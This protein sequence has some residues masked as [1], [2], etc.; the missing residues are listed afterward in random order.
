MEY[1]NIMNKFVEN[2]VYGIRWWVL[3][4]DDNDGDNFLRK[5]KYMVKYDTIMTK[6]QIQDAQNEFYYRLPS[7]AFRKISRVTTL[8][9]QKLRHFLEYDKIDEDDMKHLLVQVFVYSH[10]LEEHTW[11]HVD[12]YKIKLWLKGI[13][14]PSI[15]FGKA[16]S[17]EISAFVCKDGGWQLSKE[18]G[19]HKC[20]P[21]RDYFVK[22][23]ECDG[24]WSLFITS[25][26]CVQK[27]ASSR[28]CIVTVETLFD[29]FDYMCENKHTHY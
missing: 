11:W 22:W 29:V 26:N 18:F 9:F 20:S 25:Y 6:Q 4:P 27:Q 2:D 17:E 5:M 24:K 16:E 14:R 7:V 12:K 8:M 23:V 13:M 21:A 19:F 15:Q 3:K 1:N 28:N 10:L